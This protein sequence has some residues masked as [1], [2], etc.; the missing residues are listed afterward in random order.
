MNQ[1]FK[2]LSWLLVPPP[3]NVSEDYFI[4]AQIL[5]NVARC[6]EVRKMGHALGIPDR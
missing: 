5:S 3:E 1:I 2:I 6:E 4:L